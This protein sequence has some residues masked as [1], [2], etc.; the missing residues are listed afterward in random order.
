M[1]KL[2]FIFVLMFSTSTI[3]SQTTYIVKTEKVV[4]MVIANVEA[5]S[6]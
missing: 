2:V 3:Q 5:H 4:N 6:K 1:K